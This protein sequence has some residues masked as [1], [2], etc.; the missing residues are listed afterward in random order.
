MKNETLTD[1]LRGMLNSAFA[2]LKNM[3]A[4][5]ASSSQYTYS[6]MLCCA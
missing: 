2:D 6:C 3:H 4:L 5:R 1:D